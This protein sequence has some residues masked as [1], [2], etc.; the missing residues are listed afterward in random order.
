[1]ITASPYD[2]GRLRNS[3]VDLAELH[4]REDWSPALLSRMIAVLE[5]HFAEGGTNNA[6]VLGLVRTRSAE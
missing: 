6:P 3:F 5:F 4:P 2:V 1:M